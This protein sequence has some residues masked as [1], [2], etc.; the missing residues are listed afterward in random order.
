[1]TVPVEIRRALNL[2]EGDHVTFVM[3]DGKLRVET[4]SIVERTR[5]VF[6]ARGPVLSERELKE[7]TEQAIAD[8]VHERMNR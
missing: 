4:G 8:D 1:V 3:E 2:K 6:K 7:A 5:G